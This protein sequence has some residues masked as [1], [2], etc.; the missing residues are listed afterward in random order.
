MAYIKRPGHGN[1]AVLC[2]RYEASVMIDKVLAQLMER[3]ILALSLHDSIMVNNEAELQIAEE[4]I[5]AEMKSNYN[6]RISFKR[7]APN[8]FITQSREQA[9]EE[10][11]IR[12]KEFVPGFNEFKWKRRQLKKLANS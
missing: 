11:G 12:L 8:M 2:Q 1:F 5:R 4:L 9:V 3:G 10:L 7:E 6:V